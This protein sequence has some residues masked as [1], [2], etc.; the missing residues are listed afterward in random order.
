MDAR[1]RDR[2][3]HEQERP[4]QPAADA[5]QLDER[6]GEHDGGRLDDDVAVPD[7]RELVRE[8]A[9]E[10]G[11]RARRDAAGA[12][13]ERGAARAAAGRERARQ[14][15]RDQIQPRLGH[16]RD[17]GQARDVRMEQRRLADGQLTRADHAEHDPVEVPVGAADEQE[18]AEAEDREEPE[19][20]ERPAGQREET[21]DADQQQPGL[22]HVAG[23][24]EAA[25]Y[26]LGVVRLAA[27]VVVQKPPRRPV[28]VLRGV[29]AARAVERG[30]VLERHED[31]PVQLDVRN[32]VDVAVGGEHAFLILAAEESYLDLFALV[33]AGVVLHRPESTASGSTMRKGPCG[34]ASG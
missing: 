34:P 6:R 17:R 24:D 4:L 27:A 23:R 11:G 21:G 3:E 1:G 20:A 15:V 5:A 10:L 22:Q 14:P 29:A 16:P 19:A 8:H 26:G 13:R 7:V 12:D 32:L 9:L 25:H 28:V 30:D 31:V 33:L 2:A 18:R